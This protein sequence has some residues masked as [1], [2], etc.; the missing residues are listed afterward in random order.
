MEKLT[1]FKARIMDIEEEVQAFIDKYSKGIDSLEFIEQ[2]KFSSPHPQE[3]EYLVTLKDAKIAMLISR[4][5]GS[6]ITAQGLMVFDSA[7]NS[8]C[9]IVISDA[10]EM[11]AKLKKL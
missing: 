1:N 10:K 6:I 9:N 11:I 8:T 5:E 4:Y 7:N 3:K 2:N